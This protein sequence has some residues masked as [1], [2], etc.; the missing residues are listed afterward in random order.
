MK[1]KFFL[2][3]FC[4]CTLFAVICGGEVRRISPASGGSCPA[5]AI[6]PVDCNVM[7]SGLDMG[8]VFRTG[9]GAKNWQVL[10]DNGKVNPGYRGCW[11]IAFAP[12]DRKTVWIASEHGAYKSVDGGKTFKYMT[13]SLGGEGVRWTH[14]AIDPADSQKVYIMQGGLPNL[15]PAKWSSGKIFFTSDGGKNWKKLA[16]PVKETPGSG[17]TEIVID[18]SSD[19]NARSLMVAGHSGLFISHDNGGT[20]QSIA[21]NLP[22]PAGAKPQFCTL[23]VVKTAGKIRTLLTVLPAKSSDGKVYGGVY[24]SC[25]FG[26][27]WSESNGGLDIKALVCGANRKNSWIVRSCASFPDRCYLGIHA[28]AGAVFRSDDGGKNWRKVTF[29]DT[30]YKKVVNSDGTYIQY[31]LNRGK[32]NYQRSLMQRVDGMMALAVSPSNPDVV[33]YN[34][35]C[36]TTLSRDGGKTWRDVMFEYGNAFAPG[37]FGKIKPVKYTHSI[38]GNGVY[39]LCSSGMYRDINNPDIYYA[40]IFDHGIMISRDGG[41]S[42][43][44]PTKGLRTFAES[45]W[46]WCHSITCDLKTPGRLYAT[47][48]TNRVYRSDDYGKSWQEIGPQ[49]AVTSKRKHKMMDSG[50]VIDYEQPE[51]LYLASD[52]GVWKTSNGGKHWKKASKNLPPGPVTT[53]VK[54]KNSLFAG[55]MLD[56]DS[57]G[58]R[59]HEF[60]LYRSDDGA[61]NWYPVNKKEFSKR[62]S[63]VA[64]CKNAPENI[65]VVTKNDSGYWGE[66]KIWRSSDG[67]KNWQFVCGNKE[68]R[69]VA[70]NPWDPDLIYSS[71]TSKDISKM[72][73][74]WVRSSDGGKH[75]QVISGKVAMSGRLYNLL[76]DDADPRRIYYHEPYSVCEYFDREAATK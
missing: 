4:S 76:I 37:L 70:V 22:L 17:F 61:E 46:G 10:G 12:T 27:T 75:W 25:D 26:K 73:P 52:N 28:P 45:G 6:D 62:I 66:G 41:K 74:A 43:E 71:Y 49:K 14:I 35:N 55:S 32:G 57:N 1:L 20:W 24:L 48:A 29:P 33:A 42:W 68:Y 54:I 65:Y 59:Y 19:K 15:A 44:S 40:G 5:L 63:C 2:T 9:N 47:F 23:D 3:L 31:M 60:G 56:S 18:P 51:T 21:G 39:L 11:E 16:P 50:V 30:Y 34:D 69:F 7:L 13:Q 72:Q 67:G 53:L 64:Y 36:G 58:K 8:Y 38:K